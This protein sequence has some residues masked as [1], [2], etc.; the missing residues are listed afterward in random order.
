MKYN[1]KK[2]NQTDIGCLLVLKRLIIAYFPILKSLTSSTLSV[3]SSI[4][5]VQESRL[6][7]W[8]LAPAHRLP[9]SGLSWSRTMCADHLDSVWLNPVSSADHDSHLHSPIS[10]LEN[11]A[12]NEWSTG[13]AAYMP[14]DI[15]PLPLNRWKA[16]I[17]LNVIPSRLVSM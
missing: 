10:I 14:N 3:I 4:K 12:V 7:H 15:S 16:R 17:W 11:R 13:L 8:L 9:G 6:G 2:G 5:L 1:I